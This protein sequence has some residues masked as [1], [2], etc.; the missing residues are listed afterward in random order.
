MK[1]TKHAN[2]KAWQNYPENEREDTTITFQDHENTNEPNSIPVP[3]PHL[4]E[5]HTSVKNTPDP[6]SRH[7][8]RQHFKHASQNQL[9]YKH[10]NNHTDNLRTLKPKT[11]TQPTPDLTEPNQ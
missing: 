10:Q 5:H 6:L 9:A 2:T 8:C 3:L 1:I 7:N 4:L 11:E